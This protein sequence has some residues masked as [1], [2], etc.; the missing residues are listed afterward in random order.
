MREQGRLRQHMRIT[1]AC[2][3]CLL[4]GVFDISFAC[5]S[6]SYAATTTAFTFT[7][8]FTLA[9]IFVF[10]TATLPLPTNTTVRTDAG[11]SDARLICPADD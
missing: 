10:S 7:F 11:P 4:L 1:A 6:L 8:L 5:C 9:F 3:E 2:G